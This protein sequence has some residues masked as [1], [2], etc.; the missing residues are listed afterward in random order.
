MAIL[1]D[2]NDTADVSSSSQMA[3]YS[4]GVA[5]SMSTLASGNAPPP[6]PQARPRIAAAEE[7]V[8][9]RDLHIFALITYS[10]AWGRH[11]ASAA[12]GEIG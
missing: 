11:L 6:F 5:C 7:G 12:G 3:R 2:L 9:Q 4:L 8:R 10:R 1:A